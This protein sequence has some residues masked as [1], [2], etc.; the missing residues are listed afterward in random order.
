[1]VQEDANDPDPVL[2][3]W[4]EGRQLPVL[5]AANPVVGIAGQPFAPDLD[6]SV[7]QNPAFPER[8]LLAD[9]IRGGKVSVT[10]SAPAACAIYS[11][12]A[13]RPVVATWSPGASGARTKLVDDQLP[14]AW[15]PY[16]VPSAVRIPAIPLHA[17]LVTPDS[18]DLFLA[19]AN[20]TEEGCDIW[21]LQALRRAPGRQWEHETLAD[22]GFPIDPLP[23]VV[24]TTRSDQSVEAFVVDDRT[25]AMAGARWDPEK[26]AWSTLSALVDG[27]GQPAAPDVRRTNRAAAVS[28][29]AGIAT[30]FYVG[31]DGRIRT[32]SST[33]VNPAALLQ[34]TAPPT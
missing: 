23:G 29:G 32:T 6:V 26:S 3:Q 33:A 2:F 15:N 27:A 31:T 12:R 21:R 19:L 16:S 14:H 24:A 17:P 34:W 7:V 18:T 10:A 22:A 5:A 9:R 25:G 1:M 13:G 30:L 4:L 20:S 8:W 11:V 28:R